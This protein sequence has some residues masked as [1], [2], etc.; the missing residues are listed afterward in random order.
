MKR[1]FCALAL[2]AT[3]GLADE[4]AVTAIVLSNAEHTL[5][6][7]AGHALISEF[8]LPVI[9]QEEDAVDSFATLAMLAEEDAARLER[10]L[11]VAEL[12]LISH[13]REE[14]EGAEPFYFG[15]HDLDAQRGLRVLCFVA[16][17]GPGRAHELTSEWGLPEERA[18]TCEYD[19]NLALDS[20][21][22]ILDSVARPEGVRPAKIEVTYGP[23]DSPWR[24]VLREAELLE[25]VADYM[26]SSFDFEDGMKFEAGDCDDANAYWDPN[27]R[28]LMLCYELLEDYEDLARIAVE[29]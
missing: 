7:E 1:L 8:E 25:Y 26:A 12:W 24:D 29:Q 14:Q 15:E 11:D 6:H 27:L 16:G 10:L 19:Y 18:E 3:P 2:I 5:W 13:A 9:G 21:D 28:T 20:W 22:Q 17:E 23:S 4:N